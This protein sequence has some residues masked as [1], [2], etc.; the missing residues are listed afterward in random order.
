MVL[1]A[2]PF[3]TAGAIVL[4][5]PGYFKPL[6]TDPR[7][8]WILGAALCSITFAMLTMRTMLRKSMA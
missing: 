5:T 1:A 8:G 6:F 7:G 2:M 3:V 4:I